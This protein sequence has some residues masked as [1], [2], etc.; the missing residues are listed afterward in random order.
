MRV[1]PLAS[2]S[3]NWLP[4]PAAGAPAT[5][6]WI[7]IPVLVAPARGWKVQPG[8]EERM[9]NWPV[10]T[11]GVSNDP[12]TIRFG[13]AAADPTRPATSVPTI[14]APTDHRTTRIAPSSSST[15]RRPELT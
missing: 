8:I 10:G 13:A 15:T 5:W 11:S 4:A 3:T 9:R 6:S 7:S 12:L 2:N 14:P 1:E